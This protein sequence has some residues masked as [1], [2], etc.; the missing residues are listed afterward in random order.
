LQLVQPSDLV[1]SLN[2]APFDAMLLALIEDCI[3]SDASGEFMQDA[4]GLLRDAPDELNDL[5][6]HRRQNSQK[7]GRAFYRNWTITVSA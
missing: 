6:P 1:A 5:A 3:R 7:S 2:V 4:H